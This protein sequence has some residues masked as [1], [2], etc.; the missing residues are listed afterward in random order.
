MNYE[1]TIDAI[2]TMEFFRHSAEEALQ[3]LSEISRLV[4]FQPRSDIFHEYDRASDVFFV[5]EGKISLAICAPEVG[6]R[7]L[8]EIGPGELV[9]WSPIVGRDRFSDTASTLAPTTAIVIPSDKLLALCREQ[10]KFGFEFMHRVAHVVAERLG[11]TR[12]QLL[13]KAGH[14]LPEVQVDTD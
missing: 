3:R 2:R 10:P 12:I 1:T 8:M 7:K 9:G 5:V 4:E 14:S 11:A 13:E 6:C